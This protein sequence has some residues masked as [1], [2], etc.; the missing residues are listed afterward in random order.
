MLALTLHAR[1]RQIDGADRQRAKPWCRCHG[2]CQARFAASPSPARP[3]MFRAEDDDR[4]GANA[5]AADVPR[6]FRVSFLLTSAPVCLQDSA[7]SAVF[8]AS[9]DDIEFLMQVSAVAFR[10]IPLVTPA[11]SQRA[12]AHRPLLARTHARTQTR[13]RTRRAGHAPD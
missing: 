4:P 10:C 3:S 1:A 2:T 8:D 5:P 9:D 13:P 12:V 11:P 7:E 6:C